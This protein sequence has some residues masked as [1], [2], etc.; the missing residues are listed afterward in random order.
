MFMVEN[1]AF[2]TAAQHNSEYFLNE[3]VSL[4]IELTKMKQKVEHI[5]V[6]NQQFSSQDSNTVEWKSTMLD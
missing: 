3:N 4:R 5:A 1:V 2:A 6:E